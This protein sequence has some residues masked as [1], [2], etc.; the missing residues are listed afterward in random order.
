MRVYES[1]W[2][3]EGFRHGH[4]VTTAVWGIILVAEAA[5]LTLL[6]LNLD[7]E[8]VGG[9]RALTGWGVFIGLVV[10]TNLYVAHLQ[11]KS[12]LEEGESADTKA[13]G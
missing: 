5:V 1:Y 9:L 10:W 12:S 11:R 2:E 4:R 13:E 7:P 3:D 8:T 6:V